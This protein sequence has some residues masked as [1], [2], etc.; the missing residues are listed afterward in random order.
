MRNSVGAMRMVTLAHLGD[1]NKESFLKS[2]AGLVARRDVT[3]TAGV[4]AAKLVAGELV[5]VKMNRRLG[6]VDQTRDA[7]RKIGVD[8]KEFSMMLGAQAGVAIAVDTAMWRSKRFALRSPSRALRCSTTR[9][10]IPS[11]PRT[12]RLLWADWRCSGIARTASS[13]S[14]CTRSPISIW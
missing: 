13:R 11:R 10:P 1:Y 5:G 3:S 7:F 12:T 2:T 14:S 9:L 8:P 6:P 4:T